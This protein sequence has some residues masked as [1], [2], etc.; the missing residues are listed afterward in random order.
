M[1]LFMKIFKFNGCAS[2]RVS[3]IFI[4]QYDTGANAEMGRN[5]F[6]YLLFYSLQHVQCILI[7]VINSFHS[8]SAPMGSGE[9]PSNRGS[10]GG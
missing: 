1:F 3:S 7:T 2:G 10:Y 8:F 6:I 9:G 5:M 4:Y